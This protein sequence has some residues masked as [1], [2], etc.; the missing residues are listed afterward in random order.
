MNSKME[1]RINN[2]A[3]WITRILAVCNPLVGLAG[4]W[5]TIAT[6]VWVFRHEEKVFGENVL[7]V[8]AFYAMSAVNVLFLLV[9]IAS[10]VPLWR[11]QSSGLILANSVY[12]LELLYWN[13]LVEA[14]EMLKYHN[15]A[16]AISAASGVANVGLFPQGFDVYPLVCLVLLN[17]PR[18]R[19]K[20]VSAPG[21]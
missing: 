16:D 12:V 4:A 8:R 20:T 3:V 10:A 5:F 6:I 17:V 18:L 13:R 15:L 9:L 7:A 19:W 11:L 1:S 21:T 14:T 2:A